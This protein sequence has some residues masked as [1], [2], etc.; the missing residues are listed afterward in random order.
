ME[1]TR[2]VSAAEMRAVEKAAFDSGIDASGLMGR[3]GR[4]LADVVKPRNPASL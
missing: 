3:A 1:M 4:A 2:C